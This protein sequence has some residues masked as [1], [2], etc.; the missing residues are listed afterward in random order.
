VSAPGH[1][2]EAHAKVWGEVVDAY[3]GA[4]IEGPPLEAYVGQ[5]VVLREAQRRV[6]VEGMVVADPK[7]NPI[8]HPAVA[9][10]KQAQ[11]E[12]RSWGD[13]FTPMVL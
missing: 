3:G 11:A 6:E 7:G 2:S 8:A 12:L 9:I 10:A 1:L 13:R 5:I 4:S